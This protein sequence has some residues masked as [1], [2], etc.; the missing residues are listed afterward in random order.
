MLLW[1]E[2]FLGVH[3]EKIIRQ[4]SPDNILWQLFRIEV[5]KMQ[6]PDELFYKTREFIRQL[7][8]NENAQMKRGKDYV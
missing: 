6:L 4:S 7:E 5:E 3:D 2:E 1:R 8:L